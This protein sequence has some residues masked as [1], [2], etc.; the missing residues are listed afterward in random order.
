M[1]DEAYSMRDLAFMTIMAHVGG[2]LQARARQQL[3]FAGV[4][5]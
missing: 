1:S 3:N 4:G 5:D 2:T